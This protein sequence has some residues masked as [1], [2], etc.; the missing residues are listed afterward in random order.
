MDT[1]NGD[2][3][4]IYIYQSSNGNGVEYNIAHV[5]KSWLLQTSANFL[6]LFPVVSFI[7][8]DALVACVPV[9]GLFI[10]AMNGSSQAEFAAGA[11]FVE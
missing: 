5:C 9:I 4:E 1:N 2:G 8:G 6:L 3:S 7:F 10:Y 11:V